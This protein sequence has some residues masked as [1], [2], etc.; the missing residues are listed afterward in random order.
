L[1]TLAGG[2]A[3]GQRAER[4]RRVW[5]EADETVARESIALALHL[6]SSCVERVN[7]AGRQSEGGICRNQ[8]TQ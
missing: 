3:D 1:R 4:V 7:S 2:R 8:L 5:E 6:R